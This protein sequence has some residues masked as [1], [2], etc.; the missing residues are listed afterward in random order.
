MTLLFFTDL[1]K[2]TLIPHQN[3]W[4]LSEE[5]IIFKSRCV[6]TIKELVVHLLKT[7]FLTFDHSKLLH[8][9]YWLRVGI[10]SGVFKLIYLWIFN[11]IADPRIFSIL[12]ARSRKT[13]V[14]HWFFVKIIRWLSVSQIGWAFHSNLL[15][16]SWTAK[17]RVSQLTATPRYPSIVILAKLRRDQDSFAL[18]I[19]KLISFAIFLIWRNAQIKL[20]LLI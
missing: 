10:C 12:I 19:M 11:L 18:I 5:L 8:P 2:L 9:T 13:I 7:L 1:L 6:D 4:F 14:L 16:E 3:P 20:L 15:T 17:D